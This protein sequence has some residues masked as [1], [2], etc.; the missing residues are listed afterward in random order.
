MFFRIKVVI[1]RII[2]WSLDVKKKNLQLCDSLVKR[3]SFDSW[4]STRLVFRCLAKRH[5]SSHF[6]APSLV[7]SDVIWQPC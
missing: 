6:T 3:V 2:G 7:T 5:R 1:K 4:R